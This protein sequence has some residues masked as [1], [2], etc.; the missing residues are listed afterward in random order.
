MSSASPDESGILRF[1]MPG[2]TRNSD[3]HYLS[4]VRTVTGEAEEGGTRHEARGT[5]HEA[6]VTREA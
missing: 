4:R 3:G 5:S 6:L 2:G 1:S